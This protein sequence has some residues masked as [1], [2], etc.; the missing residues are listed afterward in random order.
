MDF[1]DMIYAAQ[2][3]AD[4]YGYEAQSRQLIEEMAELTQALNKDWRLYQKFHKTKDTSMHPK[5]DES[6][7]RIVDELADVYFT[8][9]QVAYVIGAFQTSS[10]FPYGELEEA[11]E[12]KINRQMERIEESKKEELAQKIKTADELLE[13]DESL[14]NPDEKERLVRIKAI[15]PAAREL[16]QIVEESK[17]ELIMKL[18]KERDAILDYLNG[19]SDEA[20]TGGD[21][22]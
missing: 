14:L 16:F 2:K 7:K 11:I 18:E 1:N 22:E 8:L 13:M 19:F 15:T 20:H 12:F 9:H 10:R 4:E 21:K 17:R 3:V 5:L 6:H